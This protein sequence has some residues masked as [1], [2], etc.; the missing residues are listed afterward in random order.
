METADG[1]LPP[2]LKLETSK[3]YPKLLLGE[4][5]VAEPHSTVVF[6]RAHET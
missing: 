6:F 1:V 3:R 5:S 4:E 2:Q